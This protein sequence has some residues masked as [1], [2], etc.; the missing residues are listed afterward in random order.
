M[1]PTHAIHMLT[2][3]EIDVFHNDMND[4]Q[5]LSSRQ[6]SYFQREIA[7]HDVMDSGIATKK[8]DARKVMETITRKL[9]STN[10][11][12]IVNAVHGHLKNALS[13]LNGMVED[14]R[15]LELREN[16]PVT[17]HFESRLDFTAQ[18]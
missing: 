2:D 14:V 5:V 18:K 11:S 3:T 16:I 7:D 4:F 10:D 15:P 12:G 8:R 6:R 1:N 9:E 17:K 13:V